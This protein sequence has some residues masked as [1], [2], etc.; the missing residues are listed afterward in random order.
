M[1]S[2][3]EID[4]EETRKRRVYYFIIALLVPTFLGYSIFHLIIGNY[5]MGVVDMS[6]CVGLM[7]SLFI[8]RNRQEGLIIYRVVYLLISG[9]ILFWTYLGTIDGTTS[10]W[11]LSLPLIAFSLLEKEGL[12]WTLTVFSISLA[13]FFLPTELTHSHIYTLIHPNPQK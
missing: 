10:L 2:K 5:G 11:L 3:K 7:I 4:L 12:F 13:I 8:L 1:L 6:L 9:T